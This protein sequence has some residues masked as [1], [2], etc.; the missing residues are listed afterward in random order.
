MSKLLTEEVWIG[1]HM[2][3]LALWLARQGLA[4]ASENPLAVH[5]SGIVYQANPQALAFGVQ[6]G[7]AKASAL[8]RCPQLLWIPRKLQAE[9]QYLQEQCWWLSRFTPNLCQEAGSLLAEVSSSLKLFGGLQALLEQML[10]GFADHGPRLHLAVASTARAA[11]W[12]SEWQARQDSNDACSHF[13]FSPLSIALTPSDLRK[14]IGPIDIDCLASQIASVREARNLRI[15][16]EELGLI[17]LQRL[18][19]M[20]R[21]ALRQRLGAKALHA[22]DQALG[23][24]PDPRAWILVPEPLRLHR[25]LSFWAEESS[26]LFK[27]GQ[28]LIEQACT[29]LKARHLGVMAMSFELHHRDRGPVSCINLGTQELCHQTTRW[30]ALWQEHLQKTRLRNPVV[31]ITLCSGLTQ[32]MHV[33]SEALFP[34]PE[35]MRQAQASLLER[36][37]A[38]L[39]SDSICLMVL[40]PD[41]RPEFAQKLCPFKASPQPLDTP[42][43][44]VKPMGAK[45]LVKKH[46][47]PSIDSRPGLRAPSFGLPRPIWFFENPIPIRERSNRPYWQGPLKLIAG[48]ERIET[49]WWDGQWFARDYFIAA[50]TNDVLY[51]IYRSRQPASEQTC[52]DWF[53]QGCFG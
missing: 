42:R 53:V 50:D 18:W 25:A 47:D 29:Y 15:M 30:C 13:D 44:A 19:E 33:K 12:L 48:P 21:K 6:S 32:S 5:E 51:W 35:L 34:G 8:S 31:G 36:L 10:Q 49:A 22:I 17:N 9:S 37:Q 39:G 27:L 45:T 2:D 41:H 16:R 52:F 7:M 43:T 4:E 28:G 24:E 20:P 14:A 40:T 11:L 46:D 23:L 26:Q 1:F 3:R 38:R